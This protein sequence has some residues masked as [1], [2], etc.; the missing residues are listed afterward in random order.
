MEHF[1]DLIL[2]LTL[3]FSEIMKKI[4]NRMIDGKDRIKQILLYLT[5]IFFFLPQNPLIVA[6]VTRETDPSHCW[7]LITFINHQYETYMQDIYLKN[8]QHL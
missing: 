1:V 7:F 8:Q 2:I 5:Y 6:F 3:E 4:V